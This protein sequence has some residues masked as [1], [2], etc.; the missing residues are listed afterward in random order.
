[1]S[2]TGDASNATPPFRRRSFEPKKDDS[3]EAADSDKVLQ[4]RKAAWSNFEA[5]LQEDVSRQ[6]AQAVALLSEGNLA[7]EELEAAVRELFSNTRSCAA[8]SAQALH[9]TML[10]LS[11]KQLKAQHVAHMLKLETARTA[12]EVQLNNQ[13]VE[14]EAVAHRELEKKVQQLSSNEGALLAEAHARQ[15][16]LQKEIAGL[17]VSSKSIEEKMQSTHKL[18]KAAEAKLNR[19]GERHA[20]SRRPRAPQSAWLLAHMRTTAPLAHTHA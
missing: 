17:K 15:E 18:Y 6:Q 2:A 4:E 19:Q 7:G 12:G 16:E 14:M 11:R 20:R 9:D 1:M 3:D 8:R 13:K 10:D 5:A